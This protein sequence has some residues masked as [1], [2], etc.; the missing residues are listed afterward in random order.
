[1]TIT[2]GS[3]GHVLLSGLV[4][5]P[6]EITAVCTAFDSGGHSGKIRGEFDFIPPGDLRQCLSALSQKDTFWQD[7]LRYRF[8]NPDSHLH[9][10]SVGNAMLAMA[11]EKYGQEE[12]MRKL[13]QHLQVKGL[14]WPVTF[15]KA[16][17]EVTFDD[18][19][20]MVGETKIDLRPID[21]GREIRSLRLVGSPYPQITRE[22]YEA[23]VSA[24]LIVLG[25]GDL[26]T[27]VLPCLMVG[28]I[29]DAIQKSNAKIIYIC[30]LMTKYCETRNFSSAD[31]ERA[32]NDALPADR[33]LD[34]MIINSK[35]IPRLVLDKY[36]EEKAAPVFLN[37]G[38]DGRGG[39]NVLAG[40]LVSVR[41][42]RDGV[43]R[44]DSAKLAQIIME[45]FSYE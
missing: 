25:P 1:M 26:Y 32:I 36:A 13:N 6:V 39:V 34:Y 27:S 4:H 14:V 3:G 5:R 20:T 41:A 11:F 7:M 35:I 31:F 12:G 44:H 33:K 18:G 38:I 21:D 40:D 16:D 23:I 8:D 15:D 24:D 2:G 10:V 28:G 29:H 9:G 37:T 43:V 45:T 22:A 30:S 17:L 42:L 19:S